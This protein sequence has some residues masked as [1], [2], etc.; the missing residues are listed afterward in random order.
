MADWL[1]RDRSLAG[2]AD[3]TNWPQYNLCSGRAAGRL[4]QAFGANQLG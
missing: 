4:W 1:Q 3:E 2:A